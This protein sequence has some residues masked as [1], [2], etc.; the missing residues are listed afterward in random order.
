MVILREL[1]SSSKTNALTE[2]VVPIELADVIKVF[3]KHHPKALSQLWGTER[4]VWHGM[5]FF[6]DGEPSKAL[7]QAEQTVKSYLQGYKTDVSVQFGGE[8]D[9]TEM[10][11]EVAIDINF[12][13]SDNTQCYVGY[14]PKKDV[15]LIGYE[16]LNDEEDFTRQCSKVFKDVA[17]ES[18]DK[19]NSEHS[20]IFD[21][22]CDTFKKHY[23]SFGLCF[24]IYFS[25]GKLIADEAMPPMP[26]GFYKSTYRSLKRHYSHVIDLNGD[27]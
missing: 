3:P 22:A 17:G 27:Y 14:D 24:E 11:S 5:S 16:T 26:G 19:E 10:H 8:L 1:L 7:V 6:E 4:L 9:G 18:F 12:E 13:N 20:V 23:G 21:D 2:A 25:G 15:L